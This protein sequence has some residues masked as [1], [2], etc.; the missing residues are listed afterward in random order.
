MGVP[1]ALSSW[2]IGPESDEVRCIAEVA[3]PISKLAYRCCEALRTQTNLL[4]I[5]ELSRSEPSIGRSV[6]QI[7]VSEEFFDFFFNSPIGYRAMFRRGPRAGSVANAMI[8][9]ATR[10]VLSRT[11][12]DLVETHVITLGDDEPEYVGRQVLGR[13]AFVRSLD[14]SLAKVW[15]STAE[16][17]ERGTV[18]SLPFGVSAAKIDVG[19]PNHWA[20]I[21]QD[22]AN[23]L[24][25]VKGAF[26]G[27]CG[28]F[29]HKDPELRAR[30]LS[31][32]G[33]A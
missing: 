14:P 12:S 28:L 30:T 29:Q 26:L 22:A 24:L 19:L 6:V 27:P 3:D 8:V 2:N 21:H 17:G 18:R 32:R 33:E 31:E 13:S 1:S 25:E 9:S 23:C 7:L 20:A 10:D 15:Y 16:I 5:W 11:L 4:P